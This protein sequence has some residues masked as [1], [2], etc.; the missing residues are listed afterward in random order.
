VAMLHLKDATAAPARDMVSVGAGTIDWRTVLA[1]GID[2]GGVSHAFVEHDNP[3]DAFAS[4]G[5]SAA[6]LKKEGLVA[7]R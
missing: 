2:R 6:W 1:R 3:G 7:S 4:I 5:A